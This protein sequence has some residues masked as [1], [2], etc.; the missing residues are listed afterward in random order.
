VNIFSLFL[1]RVFPEKAVIHFE[2]VVCY[3]RHFVTL[4]FV[5]GRLVGLM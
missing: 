2:T 1:R 4:L 3:F 5:S